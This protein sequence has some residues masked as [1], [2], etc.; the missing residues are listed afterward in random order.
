[1]RD[2]A[3]GATLVEVRAGD[4]LDGRFEL[5][6]EAGSGG[7]GTVW[8]ARDRRDGVTVAVKALHTG[9]GDARFEREARVLRE[10]DH[11]AIVRYVAHGACSSG[12][13]YLVMEWLEGEDG[14][15]PSRRTSC[16]SWDAPS[17]DS[18][19]SLRPK[20]RWS[21]VLPIRKRWGISRSRGGRG[22]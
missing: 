13:P 15:R 18:R 2:A 12:A 17:S 19:S 14:L 6:R 9:A 11:P 1:M 5:E 4:L 10:L 3:A 21:S 7:M 22:P 16:P 8:R 20:P